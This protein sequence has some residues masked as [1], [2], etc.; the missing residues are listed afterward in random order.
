MSNIDFSTVSLKQL[1]AIVSEKLR[2]HHIDT[3]LVGGGC[4][5]I[6]SQ[7]RYQSY[8]LDYVTHEDMNHVEQVLKEINFVKKGRH[9]VH[10][11]CPFFLEF[12]APPV[13][14]GNQP[15]ENYE[16]YKT[17]LGT[18]KMLKATDSIKDRL[19]SYYHWDDPQA[20]EQA[21]ILYQEVQNQ[22]DLNEIKFW[23][24][25]EGHLSKFEYFL[26]QA[27]PSK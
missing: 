15:I 16:Y 7:N 19:A 8:D 1:A 18:I 23:S 20:L 26:T 14:I 2:S 25:Q 24:E 9:F 13:A 22:V 27:N 21:I 10:P 12:I 6:Y 17:S 11:N 3:T 5:S 4:V